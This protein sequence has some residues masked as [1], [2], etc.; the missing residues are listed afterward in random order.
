MSPADPFNRLARF[1]GDWGGALFV[2]AVVFTS[3]EVLMRYV[4]NAPTV[5]VHEMTIALSAMAF[6]ISGGYALQRAEHIRITLVYDALA[7]RVRRALDVV[8]TLLSGYFLAALG[9]GAA[10]QAR[11]ALAVGETT[12]TAAD[13]PAPVIL[14]TFLAFGTILMLLQS[15]VHLWRHLRGRR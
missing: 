15:F 2:L 10:I 11:K 3:Y 12:G 5:W 9:L 14:K 1:L 4:F 7:P 6:I 13:L 8:N